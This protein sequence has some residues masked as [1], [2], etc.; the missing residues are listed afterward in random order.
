MSSQQLIRFAE[1]PARHLGAIR[2]VVTERA[3]GISEGPFAS[4]NLGRFVP[5]EPAHVATNETRVAAALGLDPSRI[6][7]V[8]LEHGARVVRASTGGD[9]GLA[10][11]LVTSL[12]SSLALT[13]TVAD[14]FPVAF[15]GP[16]GFAL[17]H[18]GWRGVVAGVLE[19]TA[20]ALV[21]EFGT[22]SP[23]SLSVWIGPGIEAACYPVGPEVAA[24][25]PE[26]I[27]RGT[28]HGNASESHLDLASEITR[29]LLRIG[30][31]RERIALAN[32]CTSCHPSR[33][34]SHRRDGYPAGR[35]AAYVWEPRNSGAR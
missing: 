17:A 2:A 30:I 6:A 9:H 4:L 35:M 16:G 33:F 27:V 13:L 18:C 23:E 8:R 25:F 20:D 34:F 10:D 5:D 28:A 26:S 32:L 14:C 1:P 31:A 19:A 24:Q 12:G 15:A 7:R 29:R 3:G 22:R 21:E 11:A